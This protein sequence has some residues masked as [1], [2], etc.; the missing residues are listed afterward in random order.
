MTFTNLQQHIIL[1]LQQ[2]ENKMFTSISEIKKANR[3]NGYHFFSKNT[4]NFFNS[5]THRGVYGGRYFI[6]SEQYVSLQG[7]RHAR[8]YTIRKAHPDGAID[9]VDTFQQFSTIQQARDHIIYEI[10]GEE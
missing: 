2:Q 4:M 5:Q 10:L 3:E 6:T 9:T 7:V 1:H 8:K